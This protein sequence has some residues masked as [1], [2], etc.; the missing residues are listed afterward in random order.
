MR[1]QFKA[2][3]IMGNVLLYSLCGW[4]HAGLVIE[5]PFL[6]PALAGKVVFQGETDGDWEIYAI[7]ADGTHLVQLTDNAWADEQ[8]RWSP[9]G[10]QIA[11][12]SNRDGQY[13]IYVM[14]ADGSQQKQLTSQPA[15]A[16][17]PVWSPDGQQIVFTVYRGDDDFYLFL[18]NADGAQ[19]RQLTPR[20]ERSHFPHWSPDKQRIAYCAARYNLDWGIHLLTPNTAQP[21]VRLT[22]SG[23]VQPA[24]TPD[25][26]QIAYVSRQSTSKPSI[27]VMNADGSAKRDLLADKDVEVCTPAWSPDGKYLVYAQAR[28]R[29]D[30]NWELAVVSVDDQQHLE[31]AEYPLYGMA[32]DWHGGG[33]S[34]EM[35]ARKGI[36]W[37]LRIL[38]ETEYALHSTGK[39]KHDPEALNGRAL[40]AYKG[41]KQGLMSYGP[42]TLFPPG[43]YTVNFRIKASEYGRQNTPLVRIDVAM[44]RGRVRLEE[45]DLYAEHFQKKDRYQDFQIAFIL[46]QSQK[47]EFRVWFLAA[48]TI[49]VDRITVTAK[50][51]THQ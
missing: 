13:Q 6:P 43:E 2:I 14:Q 48:A 9:D 16:R 11:F 28:D 20:Q 51:S 30:P 21:A 23:D 45:H 3:L 18:M 25:G 44:Q 29:R 15:D 27:W 12:S 35:F 50:L 33:V 4:V 38:Y 22:G 46:E 31:F 49:W 36:P 8:P 41:Y 26:Q 1:R 42:Y 37:P 32:P 39:Y 17:E 47:L 19:V 7:N 34:D 10:Q 24:W 40:V 5:Q